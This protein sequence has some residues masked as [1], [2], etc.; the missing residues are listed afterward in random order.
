MFRQ[1]PVNQTCTRP[2]RQGIVL[3][4]ILTNHSGQQT[5]ELFLCRGFGK[6]HTQDPFYLFPFPLPL[7]VGKVK[8]A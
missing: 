7:R 8:E 6:G 4:A 5:I 1:Q 2:W 3:I